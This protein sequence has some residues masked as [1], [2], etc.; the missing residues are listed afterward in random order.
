MP[1]SLYDDQFE[2]KKNLSVAVARYKRV[3]GCA[4]TGAGKTEVFVSIATGA[5][6][7]GHCV[8]VLTEA[9]KIFK[10]IESRLHAVLINPE[11]DDEY[12]DP[13]K[14][15]VAM[16]QTLL[17]RAKM[18]E[19]FAAMDDKLLIICDEA[20]I[21]T[22]NKLLSQLPNAKLIGFT[23][24]PDARWA[25]HLPV[26]YKYCV[27]GPQP[28]ELIQ[29]GRLCPYDHFA[30]V[31]ADFDKLTI[32]KGDFTEDSQEA[33]FNNV[34][35]FDGLVED[36]RNQKYKKCLIFT[37]SIKD[38]ELLHEQLNK[39]NLPCIRD[40]TNKKILPDDKRALDLSRWMDTDEINICVSVGT[41]TKGF[42]FP[43]LD[44]LIIRRATTS[45][46]LYLQMCGRG[47]RAWNE[48]SYGFIPG[49]HVVKKR[50]TVLDYGANYLRHG[51]W[52]FERDWKDLWNKPRKQKD[53]V[54]PIKVCPMCEFI[55]KA[56]AK[57]CENCGFEFIKSETELE[58]GELVEITELY[59][60]SCVGKQIG[61]LKADELAI[62]AKFKNKKNFAARIARAINQKKDG[63]LKSYG[64]AMGY[65]PSWVDFQIK[66]I[67]A[68][69]EVTFADFI[70]K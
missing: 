27:V 40:H 18:V 35:V 59:N 32:Q 36:L 56:S 7:N 12:I 9:R 45:L 8:L 16:A 34:K 4:A 25:K 39:A 15:F 68:G 2:F 31:G 28:D 46:P 11:Q 20:H 51:L 30:R 53:G 22:F 6:E 10:Q 65:K 61:S 60:K 63:F 21:G 29:R 44:L 52:Y 42:D 26:F 17:R 50:F 48:K 37:S 62:Y 13:N 49:K 66:T 55:N 70:L 5:H 1:V 69:E 57:A 23:A 38:C 54:A 41:M 67:P 58:M 19:Q 14:V 3:I 43:A 47:S 24:T 33:A 64:E